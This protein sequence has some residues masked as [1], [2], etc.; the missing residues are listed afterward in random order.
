MGITKFIYFLLVCAIAFL[1]YEKKEEIHIVSKEEK[2]IVSFYEST[3]YSMNDKNVYQVIQSS[4]AYI[5]KNREELI[6]GTIISRSEDDTTIG[7]NM[8]TG[9]SI[10]KKGDNIFLDGNVNLQLS[11][12]MD[13]NTEQMEYNLKTQVATNKTDFIIIEN[14]DS[15]KGKNLYLDGTN[16]NIKAD[17]AQIKIKVFDE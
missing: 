2:P 15:F 9:K 12:S 4:Q 1:F 14:G 17:N 16:R 5:Y 8:V 10:I 13:I 11:N 7:T 3:M 6:D